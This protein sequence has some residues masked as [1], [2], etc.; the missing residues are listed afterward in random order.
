MNR[1]RRE[2]LHDK[3]I[4]VNAESIWGW[5]GLAGHMRVDRRTQI[6]IDLAEIKAGKRILE[7]GCGVGIFTEKIANTK[8]EIIAVDISPDLVNKANNRVTLPNVKFCVSNIEE[9]C[10]KYNYFDSIIGVSV[11]HHLNLAECLLN[12]KKC[13]RPGGKIVFSEPNMLNPQIFLERNIKPLRKK[14]H[15]SLDE[16]AFFRWQLKKEIEKSG[17]ESVEVK[18]FDFLHPLTPKFLI[19]LI[20]KLGLALEKTMFVKEISGSL[21]IYGNKRLTE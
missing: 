19:S 17:F 1:T 7:I 8:A 16:T 20:N 18:N 3:R 6:L 4:C 5:A 12:I 21:L 11:L 15:L 2:I 13:L 14:M 10:F 9:S